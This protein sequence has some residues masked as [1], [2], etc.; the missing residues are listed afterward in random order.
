MQELDL[1]AILFL[2]LTR[3]KWIVLSV[4]VGAVLLGAYANFAMPD[5]YTSFAMLYMTNLDE[6]TNAAAATASNLTASER[7]VKTVQTAT[8]A[9]WALA[10]ASS[11]LGGELSSGQLGSCISFSS[12]EETS[13]LKISFTHTDPDLAKRACDVIANTAVTAF[14]ATGETGKA[15]VYQRAVT[16]TKTSPN[17]PRMVILGA[18]LGLVIAAAVIILL[19]LLNNTVRDKEDIQHRLNVPVLGE[20]PSFEFVAKGGKRKHA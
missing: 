18:A 16:S 9:P 11:Q 17:V 12:V 13:F 15:S 2:L 19:S 14:T 5:K 3:I 10:T 4:V 8:T 20:I 7:L 1:R 6:E